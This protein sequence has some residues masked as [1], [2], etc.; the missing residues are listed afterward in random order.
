MTD[1]IRRKAESFANGEYEVVAVS[2]ARSVE[3]RRD[4]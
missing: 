4:V 3:V 1:A 2:T